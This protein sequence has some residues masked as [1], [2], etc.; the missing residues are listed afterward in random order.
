MPRPKL[1]DP[2]YLLHLAEEEATKL[3]HELVRLN[4]EVVQEGRALGSETLSTEQYHFLLKQI[5]DR[6]RKTNRLPV[7][8]LT[9]ERSGA[10]EQPFWEILHQ[11]GLV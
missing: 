11:A 4:P 10:F 2:A 6:L 8:V 5:A 7:K 3:A 1:D 9:T